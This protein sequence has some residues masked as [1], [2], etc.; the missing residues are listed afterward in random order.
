MRWVRQSRRVLSE[1][2][3]VESLDRSADFSPVIPQMSCLRG[4]GLATRKSTQWRFCSVQGNLGVSLAEG[5]T[6]GITGHF[7][8]TN[9]L[10]SAWISWFYHGPM[11]LSPT[12]TADDFMLLIWSPMAVCHDVPGLICSSSSQGATPFSANW[13]AMLRISKKRRGQEWRRPL[14]F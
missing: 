10:R 4:S 6:T 14:R 11:P 5:E 1:S 9:W 3:E 8:A 13:R 12:K 7:R 2:T